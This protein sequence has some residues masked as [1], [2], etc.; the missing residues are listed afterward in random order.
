MRNVFVFFQLQHKIAKLCQVG[1][2]G[3][4][5]QHVRER[6]KYQAFHFH[7][8]NTK[9]QTC[10]KWRQDQHKRFLTSKDFFVRQYKPEQNPDCRG[11]T[12]N[13]GTRILPMHKPTNPVHCI[14][15]ATGQLF[16]LVCFPLPLIQ[17]SMIPV[18][19]PP[20]L[21]AVLFELSELLRGLQ[22]QRASRCH[23][24]PKTSGYIH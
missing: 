24:P 12:Q 21:R 5:H 23:D 10:T 16:S 1:G 4:P 17:R 14:A 19:P 22:T 6:E 8:L 15:T 2:G 7:L 13:N 20:P 3:G 9:S 11:P 18:P